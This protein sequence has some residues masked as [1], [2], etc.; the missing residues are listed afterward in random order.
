[1]EDKGKI[2]G[3]RNSLKILLPVKGSP[4]VL[5]SV[6]YGDRGGLSAT[7]AYFLLSE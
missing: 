5:M 4:V 2:F 6:C 7:T 3:M 1:M